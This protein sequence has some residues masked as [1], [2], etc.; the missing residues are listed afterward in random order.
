MIFRTTFE[1][2]GG[3]FAPATDQA[4]WTEELMDCHPVSTFV[5]EPEAGDRVRSQVRSLQ[6]ASCT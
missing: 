6:S 4:H 3:R 5:E 1:A 2:E